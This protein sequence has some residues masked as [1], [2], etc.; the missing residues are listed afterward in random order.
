MSCQNTVLRN[1]TK[2]HV[3]YVTQNKWQPP[4]K[5]RARCLSL[6]SGFLGFSKGREGHTDWVSQ[7]ASVATAQGAQGWDWNV[8]GKPWAVWH[9][10]LLYASEAIDRGQTLDVVDVARRQADDGVGGLC[11]HHR[12]AQ[13]LGSYWNRRKCIGRSSTYLGRSRVYRAP[14][15]WNWWRLITA[16]HQKRIL[17]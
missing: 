10:S 2:H 3:Q 4:P 17:S 16:Y 5:Q 7:Y 6:K 15:W 14:S 13:C 11:P 9:E 1:E 8:V 12:E